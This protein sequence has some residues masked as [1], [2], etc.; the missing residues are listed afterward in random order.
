MATSMKIGLRNLRRRPWRTAF[1]VIMLALGTFLVV[2]STGMNEGTY[3]DMIRMGTG[4]WSGH[5][6]LQHADY[7]ASPALYEVVD[8]PG[9]RM[10]ALAKDARVEAISA[11]I[12][13]AGLLSL[14][15]R[16]AGVQ[17][18]GIMPKT[19]PKVA[20]LTTS[21]KEG[22]LLEAWPQDPEALPVVLGAKL[23]KRLDAKLGAEVVFMGQGADGSIAAEAFTVVGLL[24]SGVDELDA[25]MALIRFEDAQ[26]LFV[27]EGKAH[28]LVG[29]LR[30][31]EDAKA[32][33]TDHAVKPPLKLYDWD[34]LMP[35]LSSSIESDRK[36]G[37][38]FMA[39]IV[40]VVILGVVNTLL[41]AVFERTR[42]IG[43]MRALGA[44]PGHI[45]GMILWESFGVALA[46]VG[47][48]TLLGVAMTAYLGAQGVNF[49]E[50]P[51]EF[52]GLTISTIYPANTLLGSVIYPLIIFS[53]AML[54][55]LWPA[56]RAARQEPTAAIRQL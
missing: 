23:A 5:F 26:T 25:N 38:V 1:T 19:E 56:L 47:L 27:L 36:G 33:A 39:V 42:E 31:L 6:Q 12:E 15:Q 46:G 10:D 21:I 13:A 43:V 50:E 20:T 45:M 53:C 35:E 16:T 14:E 48:G 4:M 55:G 3:A 7:K 9:Q 34:T 40:F 17:L 24:K 41:M 32:F 44:S 37:A 11:R 8:A 2:I 52:G 30:E 49:F 51:I 18:V 22:S 29:K 28:M 54:A